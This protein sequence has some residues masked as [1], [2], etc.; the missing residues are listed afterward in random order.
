MHIRIS[1]IPGN[2]VANSK[3]S[4]LNTINHHVTSY[5]LRYSGFTYT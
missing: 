3:Y 4:E 1:V 2:Y 5:L